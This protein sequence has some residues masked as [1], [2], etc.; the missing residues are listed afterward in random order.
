[1]LRDNYN[2]MFS[3]NFINQNGMRRHY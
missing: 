1:M 2:A 3:G